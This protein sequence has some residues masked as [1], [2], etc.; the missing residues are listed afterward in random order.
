MQDLQ[1]WISQYLRNCKYQKGLDPKTI[2]AYRIDLDQ[3]SAFMTD[4][5]CNLTRESVMAYITDL[6][7]RYK[8]KTIRRK[9]ASVKAFCG[10]LEYEE[11]LETNPFARIRLKLS[12][13]LILPRTIPLSVIK[14]ILMTAYQVKEAAQSSNQRDIVLRD[15]AV[16]ELLFA[17]GIRVSELCALQ[18]SDVRLDEGEIKIYGKGAKERFVQIANPEVLKA[19]QSY[20]EQYKN[21]MV[22][23]GTFFLNRLHKPL[24][25]Q[26]VRGI[27]KKYSILA[28]V[29]KHITP[30]MFR[31]SFATL[32]LEEGVDIRYIQRLLGHSSIVTT[33]IYTH[34]AGK[35]QRDILSE[36]HPR[37][38]FH[39]V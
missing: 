35:K 15:I 19:L 8:P 39:S 30:H 3:F 28:G 34:V 24:S 11:L 21:I 27:I 38:K 31:H 36:K 9:I 13:P 6:H 33:Q 29:E 2:K 10:Y 26:S 32:L 25:D 17:T 23:T 14:A 20:Q 5:S 7:Q 4:G 12:A 16:L 37:N 1:H 18:C 22:Q